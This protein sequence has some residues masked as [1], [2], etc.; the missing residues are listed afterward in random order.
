[1]MIPNPGIYP[2]ED[3]VSIDQTRAFTQELLD[4]PGRWY[5]APIWVKVNPNDARGGWWVSTAVYET[6][7]DDNKQL[8]IRRAPRPPGLPS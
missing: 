2:R 8:F 1:M 6:Y 7:E 4:N 3:D 5:K